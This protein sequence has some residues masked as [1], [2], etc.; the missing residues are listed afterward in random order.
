MW[1]GLKGEEESP[2]WVS[3]AIEDVFVTPDAADRLRDDD[4]W[5]DAELVEDDTIDLGEL[6]AQHL[7]LALDPVMTELWALEE[8]TPVSAEG[9][10]DDPVSS[11]FAVLSIMR[12]GR[13]DRD[14]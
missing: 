12:E 4:G 2:F 5:L 3:E 13:C 1:R 14:T 9:V 11:P 6:V 8:G 10:A 7:S